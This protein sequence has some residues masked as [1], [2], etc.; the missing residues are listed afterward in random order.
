[1][2][3]LEAVA[4]A[5]PAIGLMTADEF[6][7]LLEQPEHQDRLLELIEG[8]VVEK[9]PTEEHGL[10]TSNLNYA[11]VA[12]N[13]QHKLGRIGVEVRHRLPGDQRNSRMP[14]LSFTSARRPLVTQ[15]VVP[16]MPDLAVEIK[17][18]DDSI[19]KQRAKATYYLEHGVRL[20]W[21]VYPALRLVEVYTLD[22]EIEILV[23]GDVLTGGDVLPGFNLPI[24]DIFADP[25]SK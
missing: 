25:L 19:R 13:R 18:P 2:Q 6:E 16:E 5:Q 12:Y 7:Q 4:T 21:L 23:A 15:G 9:L 22:G 3:R 17:S 20:V 8:K 10:V 1:M 11:L 14:D 24:A